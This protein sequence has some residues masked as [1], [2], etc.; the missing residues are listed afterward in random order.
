ME[1]KFIEAS[2]VKSSIKYCQKLLLKKIKT[3]RIHKIR[4]GLIP[5]NFNKE[6][7]WIKP[8]TKTSKISI[9][10]SNLPVISNFL[11]TQNFL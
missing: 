4:F 7:L 8:K 2:P 11:K 5:T 1:K 9:E 6:K 10:N 3:T